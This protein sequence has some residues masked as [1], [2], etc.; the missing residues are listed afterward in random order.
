LGFPQ[1]EIL[2]SI[3]AIVGYFNISNEWLVMMSTQRQKDENMTKT[4]KQQMLDE[5]F[6]LGKDTRFSVNTK[7][8]LNA[9]TRMT[10]E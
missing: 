4:D 1:V 6:F 9:F 10:W 8:N 7:D 2:I 3:Q 5:L